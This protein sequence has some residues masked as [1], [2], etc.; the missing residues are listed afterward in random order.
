M[1]SSARSE[2][3]MLANALLLIASA[4]S[5]SWQQI[6]V[7]SGLLAVLF[8]SHVSTTSDG[9]A[10]FTDAQGNLHVPGCSTGP[11]QFFSATGEPMGSAP[12]A[13]SGDFSFFVDTAG[14]ATNLLIYFSGGGACWDAATCVGSALTPNSSYLRDMSDIEPFLDYLFGGLAGLNNGGILTSRSDNPYG[15]FAKVYIPYCTGDVHV[16]SNDETYTLPS[17]FLGQAIDWSIH[18]RGFDSLLV[19]LKWLQENRPSDNGKVTVARSSAGGYGALLNFPVIRTALGGQDSN[20]SIIVDASNGVLTDGFLN[21][22]FGA[23]LRDEGVWGARKNLSLVFWSVL[24]ADA[25]SL[26]LNVLEAIARRY[27]ATRISQSTAAYDLDQSYVYM[28][29]K[30]VD[31]GTYDPFALPDENELSQTVLEWSLKA[32]L[33]MIETALNVSNYRYYL[34]R[35]QGHMYLIAPP[36][37]I[38]PFPTNDYFAEYWE[39]RFNRI[40]YTQ[41]LY[42]MLNNPRRWRTDWKILTCFPD[43]R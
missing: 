35:G 13:S 5:A 28:T 14:G 36:A 18:H 37:E 26:W 39:K 41:W 23:S 9:R 12:V 8:P 11:A 24:G 34:G 1:H 32:R 38:F 3:L 43:C 40:Y 42:D 25:N 4:A 20:Y 33:T 15:A 31:A 17:E 6:T 2:A 27:A 16:G 29:M 22:A 10:A 21:A 30:Q 7:N 19:V